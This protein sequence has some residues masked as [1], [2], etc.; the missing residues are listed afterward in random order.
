MT[1]KIGTMEVVGVPDDRIRV[2][3]RSRFPEDERDV[4][5]NL[6]RSGDK[7][8]ALDVAGPGEHMMYRIEVPRQS[9][10]VIEMQAG[11]LE[12]RGIQGSVDAELLAGEMRLGVADATRYRKVSAAVTA[13][14]ITA[15]PWQTDISGLFRSFS[16]RG[17]GDYDLRARLLA[18]QLTIRAE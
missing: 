15:S 16:V 4:V 9:D 3:W 1:L 11:E 10:V 8:A 5:V 14:E 2:S 17:D 6:R 13:G 18:G 7:S 12:V